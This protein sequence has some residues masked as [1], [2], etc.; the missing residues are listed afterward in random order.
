MKSFLTLLLMIFAVSFQAQISSELNNLGEFRSSGL[1]II[2]NSHPTT[3]SASIISPGRIK[4]KNFTA[5]Y[6]H[7]IKLWKNHK[8]IGAGATLLFSGAAVWG[9]FRS[10]AAFDKYKSTSDSAVAHEKWKSYN[11]NADLRDASLIIIGGTTIYTIFS[12]FKQKQ[13]EK[14][15]NDISKN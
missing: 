14:R 6:S 8:L 9:H 15:K 5:C 13:Y 11:T 10:E 1:Q 3:E 4:S 7:E 12:W 2:A